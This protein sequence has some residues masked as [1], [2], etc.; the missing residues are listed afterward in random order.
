[1]TA[2]PFDTA[3][4]F[5][6]RFVTPLLGGGSVEV[7]A[8]LSSSDRDE[9]KTDSAAL[10]DGELRLLRLRAA[11]RLVAEPSLPDP[12]GDELSLWL[13][14][15]GVLALDHPDGERVWTRAKVWRR[16]ENETRAL[17][18]FARPSEIADALARHIAVG[19]FLDLMRDDHVLAGADGE[20]RFRGQPPP[21]RGFSLFSSVAP[22]VRT[23]RVRWIDQ[24][25]RPA[26]ARLLPDVMWVSPLTSLLRPAW[27]PPGWSPLMAAG[28]LRQRAYA[29]AVCHA[30]A[31]EREWLRTG[32]VVAGSLLSS[33]DL[34]RQ[35]FGG[36]AGAEI[37]GAQAMRRAAGAGRELDPDPD[38]DI[39]GKE[40]D[41]GS[42]SDEGP[43]RALPAPSVTRDP[44]DIGAVL[45]ALIHLHVLKVLEFDA[46]IS[47]GLGARDWAV[48][49]F[50]ALPLLLPRLQPVLGS[51]MGDIAGGELADE[52]FAR[53]WEE[54]RDHLAGLV[55]R[56]I[57]DNLLATLV[58]RV[59]ER[60]PA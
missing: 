38:E 45:G 58:A 5:V 34:H 47:V 8:P 12:G 26:A 59:V 10:M 40:T 41:D 33:L 21:R 20:I 36:V 30:W 42:A 11:Q 16:V 46:R 31:R 51:P 52:G 25:H 29:R 24:P 43:V 48:Q 60:Q 22:E 9:M 15:H 3:A 18:A 4:G 13:G 28:F 27:A 39:E 23:E 54:Y 6:A 32:G 2:P 50:L 14:L 44:A 57:V 53:R 37:P 1:M 49:C 7:R 17:L 19:A 56:P 35:V 55:P